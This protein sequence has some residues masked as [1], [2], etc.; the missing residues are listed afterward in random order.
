MDLKTKVLDVAIDGA[1]E[2]DPD[3]NL[4]KGRGGALLREKMVE[5]RRSHVVSSLSLFLSLLCCCRTVSSPLCV[6][7]CAKI[8]PP[9][10]VGPGQAGGVPCETCDVVDRCATC[11]ASSFC[12]CEEVPGRKQ[13]NCVMY[14]CP[15]VVRC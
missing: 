8:L 15:F 9:A 1:D 6:T 10:L 5:V 11:V 13:N 3:L 7:D 14:C 2:V 12:F 4:V